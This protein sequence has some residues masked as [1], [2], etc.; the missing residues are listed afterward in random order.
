MKVSF[1][2]RRSEKLV[3]KGT[4]IRLIESVGFQIY[5][6]KELTMN[7]RTV[8]RYWKEYLKQKNRFRLILRIQ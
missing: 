1:Y 6:A 4:I 8:A 5:V 3:D 7:R 2:W